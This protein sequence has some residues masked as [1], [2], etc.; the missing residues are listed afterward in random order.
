MARTVPGSGAQISPVFNSTYGVREVYVVDGGSGYDANDPPQLTIGNCG[1]PL[2]DAVLRPI[3]NTAGEIQAVEVLD[4]GEGYSPLR[5][6]INSTDAGAFGAGGQVFLNETGGVDYIQLTRNG[7]NY[8]GGTTASIVGGG[9]AGAELVPVTGFVTGLSLEN[10]GRNYTR[11]D[12]ALVIA[13]GGGEG[14]TG[15]CEVNEFGQVE[16]INVSNPGEFFETP[17]IIQLIGGGGSGATA[18]AVVNLGRIEQINI[19]NPGGGYTSPPQVIFTRNTNLVRT[20]RNRQSLNSVLYNIT[21][22][23][24]D[25]GVSDTTI[26][27]ETTAAFP[28]SGKAQIGK[29]IFRYT[30]KTAT[31]FKGITRGINFKY[32]QKVILDALQNDPNT[33]I[34]GYQFAINDRVRRVQESADNKIAIVY[35]WRPETRELYLVFEV[36]ELAFIDAGKSQAETKIITFIAGVAGSSGTGV[37]PHVIL[38]SP[39]DEIVLFT[40]PLSVRPDSRFED[41]DELEGAGDGI[42]D[43]INTGTDFEYEVSLDGGIASSKYG[44]E[45]TVGGQNTTLL[46]IGDRVFDGSQ[47]PLVATVQ[48]AGALGDGESHSADIRMIIKDWNGITQF[49]VGETIQSSVSGVSATLDSV[50]Y[51]PTGYSTGYVQLN[52]SAPVNNGANYKFDPTDAI[53]GG[54]SS[55]SGN[56]WEVY[57]DYLLRNEP[58]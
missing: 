16:N 37:E 34:T 41:D 1:T 14:A 4:P 3:I 28:G 12:I 6:V 10:V 57:Y 48:G 39:G 43:I 15:I 38:D 40:S 31:Q 32:D 30:S 53:S 26:N 55:A 50:D 44:I 24:S 58:E 35:D 5:L 27:V 7:D 8:F 54:S 21:G 2:R 17:P 22:L 46:Q 47:S 42:I 56:L 20:A 23:T 49:L 51:S 19:T 29:E 13:G 33:G 36:D 25:V 52:L 9:G 18:E 45:E 11:S